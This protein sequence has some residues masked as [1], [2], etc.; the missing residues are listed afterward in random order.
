M[1]NIFA[2]QKSYITINIYPEFLIGII[3][4]FSSISSFMENRKEEFRFKEEKKMRVLSYKGTIEKNLLHYYLF[5][6]KTITEKIF[7]FIFCNII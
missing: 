4:S 7:Y 5:F 3:I 2:I 1:R 6:K